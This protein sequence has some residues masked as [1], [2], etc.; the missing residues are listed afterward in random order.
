MNNPEKLA[1][2]WEHKTHME[3]K[4]TKSQHRNLNRGALEGSVVPFSS[5]TLAV[6]LIKS[7]PVKINLRKGK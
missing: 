2:Y 6:L 4:Q 1:I 7:R 5:K 3:D